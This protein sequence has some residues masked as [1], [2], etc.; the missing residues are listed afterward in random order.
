M[1]YPKINTLW[2]RDKNRRI[3]PKQYS[4]P[5]FETIRRW[6]ITEKINGTNVRIICT[7]TIVRPHQTLEYKGK[8]DNAQIPT[9]LLEALKKKFTANKMSEQFKDDNQ[10]ILFGE[11]YG[12]KIQQAGKRY[13]KDNS[14]ILFDGE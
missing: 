1:K 13:R 5:E 4:K 6:H 10:V 12:N 3:I 14:F 8:T 11:G 9:Q 2:K 7:K